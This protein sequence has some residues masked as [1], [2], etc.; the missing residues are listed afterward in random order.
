MKISNFAATI[1]FFNYV[2]VKK[3]VLNLP[4]VPAI[5][6]SQNYFLYH[7]KCTGIIF[8]Q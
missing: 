1:I 7:G 2:S 8:L 5:R 4:G 6:I 3:N